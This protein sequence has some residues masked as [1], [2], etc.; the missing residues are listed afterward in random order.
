MCRL[1]EHERLQK[2]NQHMY[3]QFSFLVFLVDS[4]FLCIFAGKMTTLQKLHRNF[5]SMKRQL[6][7]VVKAQ[8]ASGFNAVNILLK[9]IADRM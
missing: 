7:N 8:L 1:T 5:G 3:L 9:L 4:L 6:A 2:I